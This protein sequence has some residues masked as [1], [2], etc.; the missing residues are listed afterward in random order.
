MDQDTRERLRGQLE[1]ER[2]QHLELLDLHGADPYGDEVRNLDT[3]NDGFA[4]SAQATEERS[5]LL[6]RIDAA[7]QRVRQ[8]DVALAQMDEGTYGVCEDCGRDISPERLEVRPLSVK[9]VACASR[10]H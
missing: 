10:S 1:D 7:R 9:C 5:E 2:R 8:I 4:D 3:G 6:G